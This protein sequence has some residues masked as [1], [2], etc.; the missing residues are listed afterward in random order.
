MAAGLMAGDRASLG[1]AITLVESTAARDRAD[2]DRLLD[3]VLPRTGG[4]IRLGVTGV[5]GVGK[6]TFIESFGLML[7]E[8]GKKVAVLAIDPSSPVHGGSILGDK[9]RM[10]G[11]ALHE[12]AFIRPSPSG[13]SLGG[14]HARTREAIRLCE[15]AGYDVVIVETVGVGQSEVAV[16]SMV[17]HFLVLLL[18][19]AGDDL[20]G[21][22][23]GIIELADVLAITKADLDLAGARRSKRD[24]E[25]ALRLL[26]HEVPYVGLVSGVTRVGL[27]ELWG[28]VVERHE[29]VVASGG[30]LARRSAQNLAWFRA[31]LNEVVLAWGLGQAGVAERV[32]LIE[33]DVLKGLVVPSVGARRVLWKL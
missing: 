21:I 33:D 6:S 18:P 26:R 12:H 31:A 15:A 30:L 32:K 27:G 29:G 9:T 1:R 25:A 28:A 7:C 2:A 13:G 19:N 16:A 22:K 24:Y 8:Q 5:P 14:T 20:Q 4:A 3:L 23:K 10:A 17:D 11:L